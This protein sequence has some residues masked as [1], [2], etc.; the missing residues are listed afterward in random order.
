M[1]ICKTYM[2]IPLRKATGV[3]DIFCFRVTFSCTLDERV[4]LTTLCYGFISNTRNNNLIYIYTFVLYDCIE[5]PTMRKV[6][7][8]KYACNF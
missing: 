4:T 6:R 2:Y 1:C 5:F 3:V 7:H 8:F